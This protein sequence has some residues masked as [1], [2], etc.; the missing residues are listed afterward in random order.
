M[1]NLISK[2]PLCLPFAAGAMIALTAC[3]SSDNASS[4][5]A[6]SR[7]PQSSPASK[8]RIVS[9]CADSASESCPGAF[10][11]AMSA[12]GTAVVGGSNDGHVYFFV[13]P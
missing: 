10:G 11:F 4:N 5:S 3:Q 9:A 7:E 1:R 8:L 13:V 2:T 12:D 6:A